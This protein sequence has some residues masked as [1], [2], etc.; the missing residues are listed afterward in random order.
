M[1]RD[2]SITLAGIQYPCRV[3]AGAMYEYKRVTGRDMTD[4]P[5]FGELLIFIWACA[6]SGCKVARVDFPF[7]DGNLFP[8]MISPEES[9]NLVQSYVSA[10]VPGPVETEDPDSKKKED[11]P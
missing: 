2:F 8:D 4:N 10:I 1:V 5:D 11:Q 3:T 9:L 7:T 6:R